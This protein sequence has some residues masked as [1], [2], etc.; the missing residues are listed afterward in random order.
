MIELQYNDLI[1]GELLDNFD[2]LDDVPASRIST[3]VTTYSEYMKL[4]EER[5]RLEKTTTGIDFLS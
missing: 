4:M 1:S 3:Q 2:E 5:T